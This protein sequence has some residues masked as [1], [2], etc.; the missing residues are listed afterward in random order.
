[1]P[2]DRYL[3]GCHQINI[4]KN[5]AWQFDIEKAKFELEW[6][7]KRNH[8]ADGIEENE[9]VRRTRLA[10]PV[11]AIQRAVFSLWIDAHAQWRLTTFNVYS[12]NWVYRLRVRF[13]FVLHTQENRKK[14]RKHRA[15]EQI[16]CMCLHTSGT[17]E[18]WTISIARPAP[19]LTHEQVSFEI[20]GRHVWRSP[21]PHRCPFD[22]TVSPS[23]AGVWL[24]VT[25]NK[26]YQLSFNSRSGTECQLIWRATW[27]PQQKCDNNHSEKAAMLPAAVAHFHSTYLLPANGK[28]A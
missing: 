17:V 15:R 3:D 24:H 9:H 5:V 7:R 21:S 8:S 6:G 19:A 25:Y 14:K 22:T 16:Y 11:C 1:M 2:I 23:G 10:A 28:K 27:K 26:Y 13:P 18:H 4:R 12:Q 20:N